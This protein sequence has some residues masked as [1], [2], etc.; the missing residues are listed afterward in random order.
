LHKSLF[1]VLEIKQSKP[2]DCNTG[3]Q[4]VIELVNPRLVHCLA[5]KA[6]VKAEVELNNDIQE[7]FVK[8]ETYKI[9]ITTIAFPAMNIKQRY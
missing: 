6:T 4:N 2:N 8:I 7:V 3:K 5:T 9:C 1:S